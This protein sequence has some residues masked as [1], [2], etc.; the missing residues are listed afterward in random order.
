MERE[1]EGIKQLSGGEL[2]QSISLSTRHIIFKDGKYVRSSLV[3]HPFPTRHISF[4]EFNTSNFASNIRLFSAESELW[5]DFHDGIRGKKSFIPETTILSIRIG[6]SPD[7]FC[8][9]LIRLN[10]ETPQRELHYYPSVPMDNKHSRNGFH[11]RPLIK[12]DLLSFKR[13]VHSVLREVGPE[14]LLK[15]EAQELGVV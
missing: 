15:L 2:A 9:F 11:T 8:A 13:S 6:I 3:Y 1:S 7:K 10:G 4:P 14:F 5:I 12:G